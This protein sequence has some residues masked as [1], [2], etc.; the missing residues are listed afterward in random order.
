MPDHHVPDDGA[1]R[2]FEPAAVRAARRVSEASIA[3]TLVGSSFAIAFGISSGSAALVAFGAVGYVDLVGS[4]ALVH[5][6][7]H[8]LRTEELS[9]RFEQRAHRIVTIGLLAIG[10]AAVAISAVRLGIGH[11]P[12]TSNAAIAI[13]AISL[14]GLSV[15]SVRKVRVARLVPSAALRSDGHLSGVGAAQ[16]AVVLVGTG[17]ARLV[18][19]HWADDTAALVVGVVAVA[20]ATVTLRT[21]D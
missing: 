1:D 14:V 15:L 5:H 10:L 8:A 19:W 7:R 3:W 11:F 21:E 17:A 2:S 18:E 4:V 12:T 16:A 6:F 13:A 9:D 20:I